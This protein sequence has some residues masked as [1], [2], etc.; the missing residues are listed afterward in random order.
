MDELKAREDTSRER[1]LI[2]ISRFCHE[3]GMEYPDCD[4]P[5]G[6]IIIGFIRDL[7]STRTPVL[8]DPCTVEEYEKITGEKFPDDGL[9]WYRFCGETKYK[10]I[11]YGKVKNVKHKPFII[12]Q[13]AK[14]APEEK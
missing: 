2:K 7:V 10:H 5:E 14:P 11:E 6:E 3:I 9:V 4:I 12:V 1:E 8:P 13:T